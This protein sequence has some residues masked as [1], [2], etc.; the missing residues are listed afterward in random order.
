MQTTFFAVAKLFIFALLLKYSLAVVVL[1][2]A[3]LRRRYTINNLVNA[4]NHIVYYL[5]IYYDF[6]NYLCL[7]CQTV[8]HQELVRKKS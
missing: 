6:R 8:F 2:N 3:D 4:S 1:M 5:Q 7:E